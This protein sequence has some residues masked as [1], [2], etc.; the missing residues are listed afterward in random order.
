MAPPLRHICVPG[1]DVLV[2]FSSGVWYVHSTR[3]R[4]SRA[5]RTTRC[6]EWRVLRRFLL[7]SIECSRRSRANLS[8][9]L[10]EVD[11]RPR[12]HAQMKIYI[13]CEKIDDR[14]IHFPFCHLS[15]CLRC[16]S[17]IPRESK[18]YLLKCFRFLV[19]AA[20]RLQ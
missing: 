6:G 14:R 18:F 7:R 19:A 15:H 16:F 2:S 10:E 12:T 1:V 8:I 5:A 20:N 3:F 13:L 4:F 11:V 17:E 9:V